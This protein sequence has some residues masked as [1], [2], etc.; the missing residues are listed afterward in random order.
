MRTENVYPY[1]ASLRAHISQLCPSIFIC[2]PCFQLMQCCSPQKGERGGKGRGRKGGG[3]CNEMHCWE[4]AG[5][6]SHDPCDVVGIL[7]LHKVPQQK[8]PKEQ[9]AQWSVVGKHIHNTLRYVRTH[10]HD[11]HSISPPPKKK[12]KNLT[13]WRK[14]E[15]SGK[16]EGKKMSAKRDPLGKMTGIW[17]RR[18]VRFHPVQPNTFSNYSFKKRSHPEPTDAS[19]MT[20]CKLQSPHE[21]SSFCSFGPHFL[22][23]IT[24]STEKVYPNYLNHFNWRCNHTGVLLNYQS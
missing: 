16:P 2:S 12:N 1:R 22:S 14:C 21:N 17:M 15:I 20:R 18:L 4:G 3:G 19:Y 10:T 24:Q 5:R 11:I 23:V 9:S 7:M 8:M 6:R 13:G